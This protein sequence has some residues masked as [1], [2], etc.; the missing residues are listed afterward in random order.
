MPDGVASSTRKD[1][2]AR[3]RD[4]QKRDKAGKRR[5]RDAASA[6]TP[7]EGG[8]PVAGLPDHKVYVGTFHK[9][10]T[11][12]AS[13]IFRNACRQLGMTRFRAGR[14]GRGA[15][16]PWQINIE[17]TSDFDDQ[18]QTE[19]GRGVLFIRDPRAVI[20]S[21]ASYHTRADERWLLAPDERFGGMTYRDKIASLPTEEERL[22]FEL[23][24]RGGETV[25]AMLDRTTRYPDFYLVK[26]ED[27]MEDYSLT[28]FHKVFTF[29]GFQGPAIIR[30]LE[31]SLA[32]S[33]FNDAAKLR[34]GHVSSRKPTPWSARFTQRVLDA[35]NARF[36]DAA[37]RLGY[38]QVDVLP[39]REDT[40]QPMEAAAG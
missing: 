37:P 39:A 23:E 18:P 27:L 34:P 20:V 12:L 6:P 16:L 2:S 1:S 40:T 26:L 15:A 28:E 11:V 9:T 38:P 22:L 13:T 10:G 24:H 3:R 19:G 4:P 30:L 17:S 29:L 14:K 8:T 31:I 5:R 35:F 32:N 25:A 36:P 33:V 7:E 21:G